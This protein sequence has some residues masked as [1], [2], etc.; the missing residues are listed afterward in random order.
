MKSYSSI[1]QVILRVVLGIVFLAHG[2]DKFQSGISNISG[3]FESVGVPGYM[4]AIV[5]VI[6]TAGGIALILGAGTRIVSM[7]LAFVLLVAIFTAKISMGF[8]GGYE[9]DIALLAIAVSLVFTGSN[10]WSID[11]LFRANK[12]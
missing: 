10:L 8:L 7:V 9:L 2:L 11:S 3:F 6:E 12:K 1:G 5:A 4:A